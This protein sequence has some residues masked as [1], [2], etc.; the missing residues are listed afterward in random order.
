MLFV[1]VGECLSQEQTTKIN[2]L[3]QTTTGMN[4][5]PLLIQMMCSS[6]HDFLK[7]QKQN[8]MDVANCEML[9]VACKTTSEFI[10]AIFNGIV[11]YVSYIPLGIH[12]K[13]S[14]VPS[15]IRILWLTWCFATDK[16]IHLV[17]AWQKN[18]TSQSHQHRNKS[19]DT[20]SQCYRRRDA[21]VDRNCQISSTI[22]SL[23]CYYGNQP[24]KH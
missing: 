1:R 12:K 17:P 22:L 14:H 16:Y 15:M 5:I 20:A 10:L 23:L 3:A 24:T 4:S 19:T 6:K 11:D 13:S 2:E 21:T 7:G 9:D 8:N 18:Y